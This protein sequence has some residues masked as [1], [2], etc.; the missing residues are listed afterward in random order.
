MV[1]EPLEP[2]PPPACFDDGSWPSDLN[3]VAPPPKV[4]EMPARPLILGAITVWVVL[5]SCSSSSDT[6]STPTP[7]TTSPPASQTPTS[8]SPEMIDVGGFRLAIRCAGS[9]RP[10]LIFEGGHGDSESSS[11]FSTVVEVMVELDLTRVC[12]Y[13]RAGLGDSDDRPERRVAPRVL[14]EELHTLL[15]KAGIDP[16]YVLAGASYGGPL[17]RVYQHEYPDEVSGLMLIDAVEEH[18]AQ[19]EFGERRFI[20]GRSF[21]TRSDLAAALDDA[22]PLGDLPV[23]IITAGTGAGEP[24]WMHGQRRLAALST[25][26]I[27]VVARGATHHVTDD[28]PELVSGA[29]RLL[30]AAA[31]TGSPLAGCDAALEQLG[32]RC[33]NP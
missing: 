24:E 2:T 9:G 6:G 3:A 10:A 1:Q 11:D 7:A 18:I 14:A 33:L 4:Q 5:A 25:N 29:A 19:F 20:E 26:D 30:L 23:V 13:D 27:H 16:P 17:V 21:F 28:A 32:A 22:G 15:G 31:R 12:W 8:V